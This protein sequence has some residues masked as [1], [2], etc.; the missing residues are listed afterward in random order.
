MKPERQNTV[1]NSIFFLIVVLLTLPLAQQLTG[2]VKEKPLTGS[3]IKSDIPELT[4]S[5][6]LAG[7]Y[8]TKADNYINTSFGFRPFFVRLH[9]QIDYSLFGVVNASSVIVGKEGFLYEYDYIKEYLGRKF[10]GKDEIDRRL[11]KL[12]QVSDTLKNRDIDIVILLA[13][14]KASYFPEYFPDSLDPHSK[15]ISNYDYFAHYLDSSGLSHIDF[16][17]WFIELKDTS[18]YPLFPKGGIHWSKYGEFLVADSLIKYVESLKGVKLPYY[19]LQDIEL[20]DIP[21]YRDNDISDGM[22]LLFSYPSYPMAYPIKQ[23][24]VPN[25]ASTISAM[26]VADS[27][28]W[29]LYNDGFSS[30]IFNNGQFWYYN[31]LIHSNVP[32]W[33]PEDIDNVD[34]RWEIEKHDVIFILQTEATLHRFAFGFLDKLLEV[35]NDTTYVVDKEMILD[36]KAAMLVRKIKDNKDWYDR[37]KEK[38]VKRN[39]TVEEMLERDA[40]YLIRLRENNQ[41]K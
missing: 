27:Y 22:N 25:D 26:F 23:L 30:G 31:K 39:I 32:Y 6:W 41:N 7:D 21:K 16:N 13:A 29:E 36:Q 14:G 1:K 5:G 28:Y 24:V 12:K 2:F 18:K 19:K 9:N 34:I 40:K 15:T 4:A 3:I 8:Q 10:L 35:Y 37:V 17:K 20:S 33:L 38:A 11:N